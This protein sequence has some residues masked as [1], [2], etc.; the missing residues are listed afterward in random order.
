MFSFHSISFKQTSKYHTITICEYTF[1]DYSKKA[2]NSKVLKLNSLGLQSKCIHTVAKKKKKVILLVNYYEVSKKSVKNDIFLVVK[3]K[4]AVTCFSLLNDIQSTG[5]N[6]NQPSAKAHP[7]Q[8]ILL[9][10]IGP[11]GGKL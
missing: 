1:D 5:D 6:N 2:N 7:S 4:K 10:T 8:Y 3:S 9:L 11:K